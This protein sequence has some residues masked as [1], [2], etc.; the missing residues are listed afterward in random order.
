MISKV[1]SV[2]WKILSALQRD[3]RASYAAI[4]R[5]VGM[6]LPTVTERIKRMEAEELIEGYRAIIDETK[7]GR[8]LTVFIQLKIPASLYKKFLEKAEKLEAI[9]ECHH[10]TG[11]GAFIIKALMSEIRELEP[12]IATLSEFGE[13]KTSIVMSSP[14]VKNGVPA[15]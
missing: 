9:R 15:P 13:T 6:S 3:G 1:D 2:G 5:E 14:I 10:V 12:L 8:T 11:D 7:L 4:A